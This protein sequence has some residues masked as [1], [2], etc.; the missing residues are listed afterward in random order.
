MSQPFKLKQ[1]I[2]E[3]SALM[4]FWSKSPRCSAF[5]GFRML[6]TMNGIQGQTLGQDLSVLVFVTWRA[7]LK[8]LWPSRRAQDKHLV[9]NYGLESFVAARR[10]CKA[11]LQKKLGLV[12]TPNAASWQDMVPFSPICSIFFIPLLINQSLPLVDPSLV[13][14]AEFASNSSCVMYQINLNRLYFLPFNSNVPL[15]VLFFV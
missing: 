1:K 14:C 10:D 13:Q 12:I 8:V 15:F 4:T 2:Q 9:R 6:L 7:R 11:I 5:L 3:G